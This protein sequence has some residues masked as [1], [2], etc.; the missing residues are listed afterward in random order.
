MIVLEGMATGVPVVAANVGGVPELIVDRVTGLFC[1]PHDAQSIRDGIATYLQDPIFAEKIS[2]RAK[3]EALARF[4]PER[5][6]AKHLE[7]YR[8]VLQINS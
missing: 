1:A 2:R 8:E 6:A 7:I 4:L 3:E 5:I